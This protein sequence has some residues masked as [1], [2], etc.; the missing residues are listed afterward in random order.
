MGW[1]PGPRQ[2]DGQ[3]EQ[4]EAIELGAPP[5]GTVI[6]GRRQEMSYFVQG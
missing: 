1:P 2:L 3:G 4:K 5:P 6:E